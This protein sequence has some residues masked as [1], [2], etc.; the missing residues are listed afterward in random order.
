MWRG[1]YSP[2]LRF[3]WNFHA[4]GFHYPGRGQALP[5]PYTG[6]YLVGATARVR[7]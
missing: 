4:G 1:C 5:V 7:Q 6:G 3:R 2:H